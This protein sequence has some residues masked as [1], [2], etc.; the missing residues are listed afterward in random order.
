MGCFVSAASY[1]IQLFYVVFGV[2]LDFL[3]N[4]GG[5][6]QYYVHFIC[7]S[8]FIIYIVVL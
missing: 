5:N 2:D 6:W 4:L 7:M 1:F 8:V 3:T